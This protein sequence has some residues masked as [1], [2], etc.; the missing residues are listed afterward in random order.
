MHEL[1]FI[2]FGALGDLCLL[3][4]T[5]ARLADAPGRERFR[6]TLITKQRLAG[7]AVHLRGV[8]DVVALAE[9]GGLSD[10]LRLAATLRR[11]GNATLIDAHG[12][13]RSRL[14]LGLMG[15]RPS[16]ILRKDTVARLRLLR[17]GRRI[18]PALR[19]HMRDRFDELLPAAGIP[20]D[21]PAVDTRSSGGPPLAHL[22]STDRKEH[23][24]AARA[25]LG[26]APGAQWDAKRWPPVHWADLVRRF[27]IEIGAPMRVFLGPRERSWFAGSELARVLSGISAVELI[28]DRPLTE[29]ATLLGDCRLLVCND[30]GLMHLAEAVG[31]PVLAFFG[32]TVEAFGYT[33]G[34][35]GSE[36]LEID[37]LDC[38]PCSRNGKRPCHRGDLACLDRIEP[39]RV[40]RAVLSRGPWPPE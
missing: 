10:L 3:G 24:P 7:L 18:D 22:A 2:R 26:L 23:D 33:P 39:D 37:D 14:L 38:R 9:P 4:W 21:D 1:M 5:L 40:W 6:V 19:R 12:S 16:A 11:R 32:P 27:H 28:E 34:L 35:P 17:D 15:R 29:V 8:D 25:I 31:T 20:V 30:S 13:L 36:V